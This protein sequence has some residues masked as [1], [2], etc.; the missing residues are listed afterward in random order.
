VDAGPTIEPR[1]GRRHAA[2]KRPSRS[3]RVTPPPLEALHATL[4]D[5]E[6]SPV[7]GDGNQHMITIEP[8]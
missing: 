8:V 5:H 7:R 4:L 1:G 3:D 2:T 6:G